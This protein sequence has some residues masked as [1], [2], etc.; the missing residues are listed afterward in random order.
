MEPFLWD[1]RRVMA[2]ARPRDPLNVDV[3][4]FLSHEP[5]S[6][7]ELDSNCGNVIHFVSYPSPDRLPNPFLFRS[8]LYNR[9]EFFSHYGRIF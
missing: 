1:N 4:S 8:P 6:P 7:G 2:L 5:R 9:V 3:A